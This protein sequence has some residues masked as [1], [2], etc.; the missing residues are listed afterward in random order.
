[1]NRNVESHFALNPTNL[2][3]RRSRFDM[4][5]GNKTS[6][7]VG[8]LIPL[9][10][11]IEVLPGDTFVVDTSKV[12][13]LQ[14]LLKP[15]MDN[16][17]LDTYWFFV[18]NRLVWDHW[19]QFCGENTESAW[20][21]TT[22]YSIPTISSGS[23]GFPVGSIADYFGLP[24]GVSNMAPVSSLPFRA[25]ALVCNEWF[26]SEVL[27]D[28]L[29]VPTDD[30]NT[31]YSANISDNL[32]PARGGTPYKA[33]K[34][35]DYFTSCLP[36]PQKGPEVSIPFTNSGFLPVYTTSQMNSG[37]INGQAIPPKSLTGYIPQLGTSSNYQLSV[38]GSD[39]KWIKATD[40]PGS[41]DYNFVPMNLQAYIGDI[42]PSINALRLAFQVQKLYEKDAR[43]GTR[44]IEI[45]KSHFGVTS[46]DSRLQ[47]PEYLGGSRLPISVSEVTN[48]SQ[49]SDSY[50]G[51]L[52]GMS[53]TNETHSDFTHSFTEHGYLLCLGVARYDHSYQ[54]G[55]HASWLRKSR[56]D[57]YW[58][59]LA[60]IGEQPVLKREIYATASDVP[61]TPPAAGE[62][63]GYQ[64][65]WASYRYMPDMITGMMRSAASSG[66]DS[67]HFGDNYATAPTLSD[68]WIREDK[69][70]VDRVLAVTSSTANQIFADLYFNVK[71]TRCMP[72][73]S[74]PGL[75]D[76]H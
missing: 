75:I 2:D 20:L 46:P 34:F 68:G 39:N 14:T 31:T 23:T 50:L 8:D 60:N 40:S 24:T 16:L 70:N 27:S 45:L 71:A 52:G 22:T 21:P 67:W 17:Y 49:G 43:G 74:I 28:P 55:I 6:F 29:V 63:F 41:T 30:S 15:I 3:L 64:E 13:R 44:Y 4:S 25:Y 18:P 54:Q 36:S 73:Y 59:V 62:I 56:F 53:K 66:L 37:I 26:R 35:F 61:S 12:V 72:V 57:F 51:D 19:K 58:P 65:A 5:F 38:S 1:M 48:N 7:N 33:C 11:P 47:R 32:M 76:H 9:C 10:R 42:N 69:N